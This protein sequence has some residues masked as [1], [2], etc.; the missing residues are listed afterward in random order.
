[1][2]LEPASER[3]RASEQRG[4]AGREPLARLGALFDA[5][6]ARLHRLARRMLADGE[7]AR[8]LVQET[9]V[10]AARRLA[11]VPAADGDAAAWLTRVLVNLCRDR[12]RRLTV[13]RREAPGLEH[14]L[15]SSAAAR[16]SS[17]EGRLAARSA[18]EAALARLSPRRRAVV[19]LHEIEERSVAE[20][21][22]L[23]GLAR[24]TVRWHLAVARRDLAA[25]LLTGDRS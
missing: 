15:G 18:V 24:V 5:H 1:M 20:I 21:A 7:E 25:T 13:R 22:H 2:S 10:R 8:D 3:M 11:A 4:A 19:V 14:H 12:R 23:L 16:E 17:V 6:Q 9:F